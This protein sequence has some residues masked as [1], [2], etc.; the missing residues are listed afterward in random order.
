M[1]TRGADWQAQLTRADR[2]REQLGWLGA[3]AAVAGVL[4][5]TTAIAMQAQRDGHEAGQV[6]EINLEP[7][8]ASPPAQAI[9]APA[10]DVPETEAPEQPDLI[11]ETAPPPEPV[12]EDAPPP[13]AEVPEDLPEPQPDE[14]A[15]PDA[16]P[17]PPK[18]AARPPQRPERVVQETP[19][20]Q[21]P[22][23]EAAAPPP[24]QARQA[25]PSD[26]G[27]AQR[28]MSAGQVQELRTRWGLQIHQR[29]ERRI[30]GG[31]DRGT[32]TVQLSVTPAGRLVGLSL[33][34][35]SGNAAL[36]K[37]TLQAVQAA[38]GSFPAAP[39]GL[40]DPSYIFTIPLVV[41]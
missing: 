8:A 39:A 14:L 5:A 23:R 17:P 3:A 26:Q 11:E 13:D 10:P 20:K 7:P 37:R 21:E 18:P 9:S 6:I 41:R 29:V 36:D 16:P 40:N 25:A 2:R 33:A 38:S 27:Q 34:S 30:R 4:A 19:R 1:K 35:S 28:A 15:L 22:R 31:R 24:S 32:V 12:A